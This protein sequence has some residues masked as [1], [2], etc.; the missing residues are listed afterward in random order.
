MEWVHCWLCCQ[1][2]ISV[3]MLPMHAYKCTT[4]RA[5]AG[6]SRPATAKRPSVPAAAARRAGR[7]HAD[8]RLPDPRHLHRPL[9]GRRLVA[10]APLPRRRVLEDHAE[11][12]HLLLAAVLLVRRACA[13]GRAL[14]V[15]VHQQTQV[16]LADV[17]EA[18]EEAQELLAVP[19]RQGQLRCQRVVVLPELLVLAAEIRA[20]RRGRRGGAVVVAGAG[21][22]GRCG[23]QSGQR[24]RERD[25]YA[26]SAGF[27]GLGSRRPRSLAATDAGEEALLAS[28]E[29]L[30]CELPPVRHHLPK[31]LHIV[32]TGLVSIRRGTLSYMCRSRNISKR[33]PSLFPN[34]F[35]R[36]SLN[37][38]F[39]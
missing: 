30:V 9:A 28:P 27:G 14:H 11:Q 38:I 33:F 6:C 24:R 19:P 16:K 32:Y 2:A 12:L 13:A 23:R 18:G 22:A 37:K 25:V 29:V 34:I 4:A 3:A 7:R 31:T 5:P 17:Q 26:G 15:F 36:E 35:K 39:H 10:P 21:R 1:L 20:R 8:P